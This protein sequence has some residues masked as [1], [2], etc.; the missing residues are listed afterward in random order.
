M[1]LEDLSRHGD[2]ISFLREQLPSVPE[3]EKRDILESLIN[4]AESKMIY[5]ADFKD[6]DLWGFGEAPVIFIS[7][8]GVTYW[9]YLRDLEEPTGVEYDDLLETFTHWQE[10]E[11]CNQYVGMVQYQGREIPVVESAFVF[12]IFA[13]KSIWRREFL[14]NMNDL[15]VIAYDR[16]EVGDDIL[17]APVMK[18]EDG[19]TYVDVESKMTLSEYVEQEG[20]PDQDEAV[21]KAF[22]GPMGAIED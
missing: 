5:L 21:R 8:D 13:A 16:N 11:T 6:I 10:H 19:T 1:N 20:L 9:V 18:N 12:W 3:G 17:V 22:R 4:F 2:H 7:L 15:L 14:K